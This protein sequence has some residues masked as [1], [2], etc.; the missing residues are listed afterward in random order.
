MHKIIIIAQVKDNSDYGVIQDNLADF[1][2]VINVKGPIS[3]PEDG[4]ILEKGKGRIVLEV[5]DI[6]KGTIIRTTLTSTKITP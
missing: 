1:P 3:L 5:A 2:E 4:E 6:D